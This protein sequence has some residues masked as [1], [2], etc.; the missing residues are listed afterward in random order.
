[1]F[2]QGFKV[3]LDKIAISMFPNRVVTK[4]CLPKPV[5]LNSMIIIERD[6]DKL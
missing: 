1:M 4:L 6:L 2:K 5:L 3:R